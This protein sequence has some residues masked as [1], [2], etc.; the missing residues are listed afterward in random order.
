M[1]LNVEEGVVVGQDKTWGNLLRENIKA[2][3]LTIK[4]VTDDAA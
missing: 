2:K 1:H 4:V 3:G